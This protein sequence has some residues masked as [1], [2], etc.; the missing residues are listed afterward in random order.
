M[1]SPC[2]AAPV[3]V[4]SV[5]V[6]PPVTP[7]A[8]G[9]T[10]G[11]YTRWI[12]AGAVVFNLVILGWFKY[13]EFFSTS[14]VNAVAR[15]G[16]DVPLPLL[17][18]TLPIG[19]SFITFQAMSYVIDISRGTIRPLRAIDFTTY[20]AFFPHLVAGPIVRASEFGPQLEH[21]ADSSAIPATAA[22]MLIISGLFKKVVISSFLATEVVDP[23]FAVPGQHSG[24]EILFATYA[25]AIQ[26]FA[27]FSG[28]TD[29]AIGCALLLGFRLPQNFNAPYTADSL[30]DFWRRWHMSLSRW[31]RDY[32]F[33]PLGGSWGSNLFTARNLMITMV[34]AGLWHG[35]A[36]TF[37]VWGAIHGAGLIIE[38]LVTGRLGAAP[39]RAWVFG[40]WFVTFNVVC[41][42]WIFFR[43]ESVSEALEMIRRIFTAWGSSPLV[44]P[45]ALLVVGGMLALQFVPGR[46]HDLWQG[47]VARL[48]P[49]AQAALFAFGLMV[50]DAL[51]PKGVAPFIYFRF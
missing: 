51:G 22:F 47:R 14:L 27:D 16:I 8:D 38:R 11:P 2:V 44:T 30:Q 21:P 9:R 31:I 37:A 43:A 29:I 10:A 40:R 46:W 3:A 6:A 19:I 23:V 28:Y 34:L 5:V 39:S 7:D 20:L 1:A 42:A 17:Q 12:L 24:P 13:Y 26:I 4:P 25:Y 36:W 18:V 35:A 32:L 15:F 49:V 45:L 33:I 50:V 41:L 48:S